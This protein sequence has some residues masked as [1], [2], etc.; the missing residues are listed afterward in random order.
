MLNNND[1]IIAYT[2]DNKDDGCGMWEKQIAKLYEEG[3]YARESAI[4]Y[5]KC[6]RYV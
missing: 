1:K 5:D 3:K 2:I 6:I 4:N